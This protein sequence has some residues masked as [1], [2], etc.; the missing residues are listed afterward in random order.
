[1]DV[2]LAMAFS[3]AAYL[4]WALVAGTARTIVRDLIDVLNHTPGGAGELEKWLDFLF[5][6]AG[7]AI[8][9]TGLLLLAL[10]SILV[11]ISSRQRISISWA[12]MVAFVQISAAA[13][14]AVLAGRTVAD[15]YRLLL[16][17]PD[18]AT[19]SA[20][21]QVSSISLSVTVPVA[22]LIWLIVLVWMVVEWVRWSRR[23]GPAMRDALRTH[24]YR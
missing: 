6:D 1:M 10:S 17:P 9:V 8:D 15:Q 12:W 13:L 19:P 2:G 21:E 7:V 3:G 24:I 5:V 20:L 14:G 4:V 22:I 18:P 16:P 23:R 11:W